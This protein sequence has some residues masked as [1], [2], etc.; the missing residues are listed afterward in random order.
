MAENKHFAPLH[1]IR[2]EER[3]EYNSAGC[4][5]TTTKERRTHIFKNRRFVDYF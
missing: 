5:A 4:M 2:K 3:K 1:F